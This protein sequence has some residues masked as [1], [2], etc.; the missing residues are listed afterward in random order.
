[1]SL[2]PFTSLCLRGGRLKCGCVILGIN[3]KRTHS[4]KWREVVMNRMV[5]CIGS[6]VVDAVSMGGHGRGSG[7]MLQ[8]EL[9]T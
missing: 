1:M 2:L 4:H 3:A 9:Q 8:K 5:V 7:G 6:K